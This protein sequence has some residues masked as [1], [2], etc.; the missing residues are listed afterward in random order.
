MTELHFDANRTWLHWP[1]DEPQMAGQVSVLATSPQA[2]I[3]RWW[4]RDA[5]NAG[6]LEEAI[7]TAEAAIDA[8]GLRH[9]GRGTLVWH[10]APGQTLAGQV[11]GQN[12][13]SR[14]EVEHLFSGLVAWPTRSTGEQAA[15]L[16]LLRELLHHLGFVALRRASPGAQ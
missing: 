7:D 16:L 6:Q 10:A 15:T 12:M 8:S 2:L 4:P 13:W 5:P 3:E 1:E 9:A 14:D 11:S